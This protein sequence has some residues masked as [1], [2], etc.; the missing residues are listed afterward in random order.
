MSK[1]IVY[2]KYKEDQVKVKCDDFKTLKSKVETKFSISLNNH[3]LKYFDSARKAWIG[4]FDDD[5][6]E[7]VT[8]QTEVL[9]I[10]KTKGENI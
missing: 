3:Q 1:Y 5:D 9:L 6:L 7:D 2:V 4:I 10:P 8:E